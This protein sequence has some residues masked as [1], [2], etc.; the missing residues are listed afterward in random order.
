[1]NIQLEILKRR[2]EEGDAW[3]QEQLAKFDSGELP[4]QSQKH[5]DPIYMQHLKKQAEQDD[6]QAQFQLGWEYANGKKSFRNYK[7]A[8]KWFHKA[9]GQGHTPA[10][11]ELGYMY[12]DGEGVAQN[13]EKAVYWWEKAAEAGDC[14]AMGNLG[15]YYLDNAPQ[16]PDYASAVKWW[17]S[18]A[19]YGNDIAAYNLHIFYH[20]QEDR[21]KEYKWLLRS[22]ELGHAQAQYM[23]YLESKG[24][25]IYWLLRAAEQGFRE[26]IESVQKTLKDENG[27]IL[28]DLKTPGTIQ[29][30]LG[31][32][33]E[34]GYCGLDA[35]MTEAV[36]WYRKAAKQGSEMAQCN[37]GKLYE[38][39][40]GVSQNTEEA[41]RWFMLAAEQ[42][43]DEAVKV[44][45]I[46]FDRCDI[47]AMYK[48][49][50]AYMTGDES[51]DIEQV[52]AMAEVWYRRAAIRGHAKA[53]VQLEKLLKKREQ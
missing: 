45:D 36:K 7:T 18:A 6:T 44:L 34:E 19:E 3:A 1:M 4:I 42:N 41:K 17:E 20:E 48:R 28:V 37:L 24:V 8:A 25:E 32:L 2:A 47:E 5:S 21:D 38:F 14:H 10:Q 16:A 26:A 52:D 12:Y 27:E 30:L 46:V 13:F 49:G 50:N 31:G 15:Y 43:C 22:A 29:F 11:R 40:Q 35:N 39:G 51:Q 9:A 33:H 53:S 23:V